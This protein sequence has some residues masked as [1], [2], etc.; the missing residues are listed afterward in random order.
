MILEAISRIKRVKH[1]S[2]IK[3]LNVDID[4]NVTL[5]I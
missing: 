5:Q 3:I 1:F 4:L 2:R